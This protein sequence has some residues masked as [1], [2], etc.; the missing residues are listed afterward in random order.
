MRKPF[1]KS[2]NQIPLEQAHGGT[3]SR[4]LILSKD[5]DVSKYFEAMTKG[6]LKSGGMFD[7]HL[8]QNIDELFLV[9]KGSG[10]I[11]FKNSDSWEYNG[12]DLIY[13]PANIEH[14]IIASEKADNEFFFIRLQGE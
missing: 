2:L 6:Y 12:G 4:Q 14:K 9:T 3:G 10:V 7:W 5:D 13:I 1:K 11:E 8:H